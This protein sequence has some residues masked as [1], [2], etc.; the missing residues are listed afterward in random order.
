MIEFALVLLSIF[1]IAWLVRTGR[2]DAVLQA[3][4]GQKEIPSG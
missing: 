2:A 3:L 4:G 1:A